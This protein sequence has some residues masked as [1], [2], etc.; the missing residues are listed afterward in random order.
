MNVKYF[1]F[2]YVFPFIFH[3]ISLINRI[4]VLLSRS[5]RLYSQN[6]DCRR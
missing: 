6:T 1:A 2:L 3:H 4:F 5:A